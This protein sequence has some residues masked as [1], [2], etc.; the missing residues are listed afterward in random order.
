[1]SRQK[2]ASGE[3]REVKVLSAKELFVALQAAYPEHDTFL[4]IGSFPIKHG[5]KV[6][7]SGDLL[8]VEKH[9]HLGEWWHTTPS[10]LWEDKEIVKAI[11]ERFPIS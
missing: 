11:L 7:I 2:K 9:P 3:V 6:S 4:C 10:G 5:E 8:T 1:M